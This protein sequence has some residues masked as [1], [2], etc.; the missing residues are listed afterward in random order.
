M[1]RTLSEEEDETVGSGPETSRATDIQPA[2]MKQLCEDCESYLKALP[3]VLAFF[4]HHSALMLTI[5]HQAIS[6]LLPQADNAQ[7]PL[8]RFFRREHVVFSSVLRT[9]RTDLQSVVD[10]C[11]GSRQTNYL[12]SLVQC[13]TKGAIVVRYLSLDVLKRA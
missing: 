1:L 12:R 4:R 3:E 5:L 13:I 2:L 9:V 7:E 6:A 11:K 8:V 10:M